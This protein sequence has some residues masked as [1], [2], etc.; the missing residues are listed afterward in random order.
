MTKEQKQKQ[1]VADQ[2]ADEAEQAYQVICDQAKVHEDEIAKLHD[3]IMNIGGQKLKDKKEMRD[4][5][6]AT[7]EKRQKEVQKKQIDAEK[8][9][10][11]AAKAEELVKKAEESLDATNK[12]I[13]VMEQERQEIDK[14]ATEGLEKF[15]Q[16][17]ETFDGKE[18]AKKEVVDKREALADKM[19]DAKKSEVDAM[20]ELENKKK[21]LHDA[22][23]QVTSHSKSLTKMRKEFEILPIGMLTEGFDIAEEDG[24]SAIKNELDETVLA[25]LD[26]NSIQT[27]ILQ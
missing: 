15:Q 2:K 20:A 13:L 16:T 23:L 12:T 9:Q 21:E 4:G 17:R 11:D 1:K 7:V 24:L 19:K 18:A 27:R 6:K 10:K 25:T 8:A 3:E 14:Q 5:A 22:D 26:A